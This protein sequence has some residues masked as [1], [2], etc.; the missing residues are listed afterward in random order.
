MCSKVGCCC[1][2][3]ASGRVASPSPEKTQWNQAS[4]EE[5]LP[6]F[7][8]RPKKSNKSGLARLALLLRLSTSDGVP[9][10]PLFPPSRP[11]PTRALADTRQIGKLSREQFALAMHLIQ[12]KV[13]KGIDPPQSLTPDMIPPSERSTPVPVGS[14]YKTHT[15]RPKTAV[16]KYSKNSTIAGNNTLLRVPR[17]NAVLALNFS[18]VS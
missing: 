6:A 10:N 13:G 7:G 2:F 14:R 4:T 15:T 11:S 17:V 8:N 18:N 9:F 5:S 16:T 3:G 1:V 12:Q